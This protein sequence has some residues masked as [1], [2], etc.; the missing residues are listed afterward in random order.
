MTVAEDAVPLAATEAPVP[1]AWQP[2]GFWATLGF[3]LLILLLF[4]LVTVVTVILQVFVADWL[5]STTDPAALMGEGRLIC[6][7][8]IAG[9]L[10]GIG[11]VAGLVRLRGRGLL[12]DY[13]ALH[14]VGWRSFLVWLVLT[15]TAVLL[16]HL[17]AWVAEP[18]NVA[19]YYLQ[20]YEGTPYPVL[21]WL[22]IVVVAPL[23]EEIFFRGFMYR[24]LAGS[25][26]G[27]PGAIAITAAIW[28]VIHSQYQP[29]LMGV[30]FVLGLFF[31]IARWRSGSVLMTSGLHM[32]FNAV[33][34][35]EILILSEK[36]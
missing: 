9:G 6:I 25:R 2:W 16:Y 26:L 18:Q 17:F 3:S 21:F 36:L 1:A 5:G 30:V 20:I 33:A 19:G 24:G 27:V 8:S 29:M 32:A 23:F 11:A 31:G 28:A 10:A 13:L 12:R 35:L 15:A 4:G 7:A 22:A 34:V 14:P